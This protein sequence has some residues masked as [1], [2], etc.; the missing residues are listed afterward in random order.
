MLPTVAFWL[1]QPSYDHGPVE[2]GDG[3]AS[4][5]PTMIDIGP[6]IHNVIFSHVSLLFSRA[7]KVAAVA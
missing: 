5:T 3:L 4:L 2:R 6:K 7:H 1:E